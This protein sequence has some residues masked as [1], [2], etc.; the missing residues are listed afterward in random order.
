[1]AAAIYLVHV[2]DADDPSVTLIDGI[3]HAIINS[4]DGG[5][6]AQ[7]ISEAVAQAVA[8]G[9]PLPTG[10]F[11]T[12]VDLSTS[13]LLDADTDCILIPSASRSDVRVIAS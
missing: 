4:D 6:D 1:M 5:T 2:A 10:Y 3:T 8:A 9:I 13:G 11:D 12:V 7:I